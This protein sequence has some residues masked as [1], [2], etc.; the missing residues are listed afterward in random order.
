MFLR[1]T[2]NILFF[3][4]GNVA[5]G[6]DGLGW[7]F[8]DRLKD[9]APQ[10][11]TIEY[12]YQLQVEDALMMAEFDTVIFADATETPLSGGFVISHCF[13]ANHYFFSSHQQSPETLLYLTEQLFQKTP[14]SFLIAI[15]GYQW[16]LGE[17]LSEEAKKNLENAFK[18]L[19]SLIYEENNKALHTT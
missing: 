7:V 8:A 4:I 10:N 14:T 17:P 11:W 16:E 6:D 2:D 18:N 15:T 19:E 13:P 1:R 9:E 3:A 5:R 12:R